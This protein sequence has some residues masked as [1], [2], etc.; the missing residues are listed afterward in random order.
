MANGS[1]PGWVAAL[2]LAGGLAAGG[3][4]AGEGVARARAGDRFVT[5]KG[6]S[7]REVRADV[8]I[9]PLRLVASDDDLARAHARIEASAQQVREF[10]TRQGLDLTDSR[11]QGFSVSDANAREYG[12]PTGPRNRFVIQQTLVLR[13]REP[14]K[15]LAA[16][17][18]IGE[19]VGAG[20]LLSSGGEYGSGGPSF[21]FTGLNE[22]KPGMIAEATARAREAAEQFAKDS[23]SA[24]GGI[25]R[26]NQGLFEI[27]ARDRAQGIDEQGQ[28][29]KVVRVVAT[30]EYLLE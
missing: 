5:V 11:I 12:G 6:I 29:Q 27:L 21:L 25:R 17:A 9:W 23:G 19:L 20:V 28:V 4:L 18:R 1:G 22:L 16:S 24:I 26:A 10:L 13:S 2:L 8:A 7:E 15:V 30:L 14:E 3:W